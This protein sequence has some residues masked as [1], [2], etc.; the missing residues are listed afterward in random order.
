MIAV[1]L[2]DQRNDPR[3]DTKGIWRMSDH[4]VLVEAGLL[5][6]K[7]DENSASIRMRRDRRMRDEGRA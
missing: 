3:P 4:S 5:R 7:Q 6:G 1:A 2:A